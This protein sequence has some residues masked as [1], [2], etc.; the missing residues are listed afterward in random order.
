LY[1]FILAGDG[2]RLR[3]AF[4]LSDLIDGWKDGFSH[5]TAFFFFF[6][7]FV[8]FASRQAGYLN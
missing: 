6:F 5:F 7:V 1:I 3:C 8:A 4:G 2:R